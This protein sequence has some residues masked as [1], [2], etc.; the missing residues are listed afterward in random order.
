MSHQ[1]ISAAFAG[2]IYFYFRLVALFA[3]LFF[4][5]YPFSFVLLVD[6]EAVGCQRRQQFIQHG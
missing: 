3:E 6:V 1:S 4:V 5:A 2:T